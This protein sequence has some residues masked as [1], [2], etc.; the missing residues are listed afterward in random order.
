MATQSR[1]ATLLIISSALF[2][3][4][5]FAQEKAAAKAGPAKDEGPLVPRA[6]VKVEKGRL[7]TSV[8]VKGTV[9]GDTTTEVSVRLKSWPGPLV[10]EKAIEHGALVNKDDV[11][12]TFD[13][14]KI[15]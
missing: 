3:S 6:T 7:A 10:V 8:T 4:V 14:E 15:T 5:S 11:L 9:E 13:A 2:N 1:W 12:L